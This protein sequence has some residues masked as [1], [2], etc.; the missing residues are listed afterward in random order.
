MTT[1]TRF[2]VYVPLNK[3]NE[4]PFS[5]FLAKARKDASESTAFLRLVKD[6]RTG[7]RLIGE[8]LS[9]P[10]YFNFKGP[11]ENGAKTFLLEENSKKTGAGTE[12]GAT[13]AKTVMKTPEHSGAKTEEIAV[14]GPGKLA[15]YGKNTGS[16]SNGGGK[17]GQ[18]GKPKGKEVD[19]GTGDR[20][21]ITTKIPVKSATMAGQKNNAAVG[22][23]AEERRLL[24]I[25][26]PKNR[27]QEAAAIII[28]ISKKSREYAAKIISE[29]ERK[30]YYEAGASAAMQICSMD[31]AKAAEFSTSLLSN[32]AYRTAVA[33]IIGNK[34]KDISTYAIDFLTDS[35]QYYYAA[36]I[37]NEFDGIIVARIY[38]EAYDV[39]EMYQAGHIAAMMKKPNALCAAI[40]ECAGKNEKQALE[41]ALLLPNFADRIAVERLA[42]ELTKKGHYAIAEKLLAKEAQ[43]YVQH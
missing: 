40:M 18:D 33:V 4:S 20:Q 26:L 38:V 8:S 15:L 29:A 10:G 21:R 24:G 7:M 14:P 2:E 32:R 9:A 35:G 17:G 3:Q 39:G 16:T 12:K 23:F 5:K 31:Q 11:L 25:L 1:K 36:R 41:I 13:E 30:G 34:I 42:T 28:G 6:D 43:P 27:K 37:A 22:E 19:M